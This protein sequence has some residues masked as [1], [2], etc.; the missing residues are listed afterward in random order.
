M[1]RSIG[2]ALLVVSLLAASALFYAWRQGVRLDLWWGGSSPSAPARETAPLPAVPAEPAIRHPIEQASIDPDT[3]SGAKKGLPSLGQSDAAILAALAGLLPR[4]AIDRFLVRSD[5]VHR[6]VVAVDNLP[7]EQVP[8]QLTPLVPTPGTFA[9]A[10]GGGT[11]TLSR[12]NYE[13]YLP[14]VQMIERIDARK[15]VS[16]YARFYPLF[17]QQYVELGY[18]KGYFNDRLVQAID[19]LLSTPD[20]EGTIELV[21]PKV[22]YQFADPQLESLSAG[23]KAMIRIGPDNAGRIKSKLREIRRHLTTQPATR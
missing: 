6:L 13:R 16:T 9:T 15:A 8:S 20:I 7:R 11:A 23:Q 18:P 22:L 19:D 21:R 10:G 4:D 3:D 5:I 1:N 14:F 12:A 2:W 17:Q